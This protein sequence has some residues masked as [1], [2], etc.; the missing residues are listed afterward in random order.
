MSVGPL[1]LIAIFLFAVGPSAV[2]A[3]EEAVWPVKG[4]LVG[5][6]GG[7][8][9]DISGI[10]CSTSAALRQRTYRKRRRNCMQ[11]ISVQLHASEKDGL[12]SKGYL[13]DKA[14]HDRRALQRALNSYVCDL[15]PLEE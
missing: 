13:D 5:K 8:S 4:K 14:W 15:V 1:C 12:I 10:A 2:F 6:D 3:A 11:C 9:E 7:K